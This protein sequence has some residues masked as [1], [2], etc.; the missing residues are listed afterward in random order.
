MKKIR[1]TFE[2]EVPSGVTR[3][4]L[5][6]WLAFELGIVCSLPIKNPLSHKDLE[7]TEIISITEL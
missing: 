1:V 3:E 7:A 4:E 6:R 2:F 5:G